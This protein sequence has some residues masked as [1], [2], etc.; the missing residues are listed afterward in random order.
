MKKLGLSILIAF[1]ITA[2][3]TKHE[4]EEKPSLLS[5]ALSITDN[6]DKGVKEILDFYAGYCKYA[7][8]ASASTNGDDKKYFELELSKSDAIEARANVAEMPASNIAYLFYKNLNKEEQ[9]NYSEIHTVLIF[10][11]GSKMTFE[12]PTQQLE[13][14]KQ[15]MILVNKV[16]GLIKE[17]KFDELEPFLND[18]ALVRYDK[19]ELIAK[20]KSVD[21]DYGNVTEGFVP[22]GFRVGELKN[23]ISV[24]HLAGAIIRDKQSNEFSVD[25]DI[26]SK[27]DK[28][29]ILQYKL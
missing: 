3:G 10:A 28:I 17:K 1:T 23:G 21:S 27:E 5:N 6:E 4:G 12:F 18:T 7:V 24:L 26:N 2:C 20:L 29:Y 15:K 16:V 8:G 19:K 9:N 13:L 25:L 11:D 22:F 14:V